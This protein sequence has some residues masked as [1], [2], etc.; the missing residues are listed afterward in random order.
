[1]MDARAMSPC[2]CGARPRP[3]HVLRAGLAKRGDGQ[4]EKQA[5]ALYTRS[6]TSPLPHS[7]TSRPGV[8]GRSP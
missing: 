3:A 1:M 5:I 2:R 4:G 7:W 8:L 6:D